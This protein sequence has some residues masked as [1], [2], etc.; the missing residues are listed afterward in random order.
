MTLRLPG[1][2]GFGSPLERDPARVLE[3]VRQ[4]RVSPESALGEYGVVVDIERWAVNGEA[5]EAAR[6]ALR[7]AGGTRA[8]RGGGMTAAEKPVDLGPDA[9]G[10]RIAVVRDGEVSYLPAQRVDLGID[11]QGASGS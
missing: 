10:D 8:G 3:D 2:G 6:Q 11:H 4:G 9:G 5:T 1:G 7:R